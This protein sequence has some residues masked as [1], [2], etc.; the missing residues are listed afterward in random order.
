QLVKSLGQGL[1][2]VTVATSFQSDLQGMLTHDDVK[3]LADLKD[4]TIL[5]ATGGRSTWWPRMK[6]RSR[7]T[8]EQTR[9]Y[10]FNLHP[11][12]A[13]KNVVQQSYPSSEPFQALQ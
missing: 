3:S 2:V 7:Y 1:P 11:F 6:A 9:P 4:K 8:A 5:V 10:T 12:F 13:D